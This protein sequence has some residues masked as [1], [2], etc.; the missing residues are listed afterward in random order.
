MSDLMTKLP[1]RY[2]HFM[3]DGQGG[4]A[5]ALKSVA[6]PTD[7]AD[8]TSEDKAAREAKTGLS[9]VTCNKHFTWFNAIVVGAAVHGY[10]QLSLNYGGLRQTRKQLKRSD[11]RKPHERR[12]NWDEPTYIKLTSGPV[13]AGCIGINDRFRPGNEVIHDGAYFG[14]LLGLNLSARPS[15][16]AG[17]AVADVYDEAPIPYIHVRHN[18]LRRLKNNESERMVPVHPKLIELGFLEYVRSIRANGH[19]ALFPE[20]KHPENKMDFAKIMFKGFFGPASEAS[21]VFRRLLYVRRSYNEQHK[22]QVFS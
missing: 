1:K 18:S 9:G 13:H 4:F 19:K 15:E 10:K 2:N 16:E 22:E 6:P 5:K 17:L 21:R 14:P 12:P 3:V 20:W 11:L 8:E 7:I